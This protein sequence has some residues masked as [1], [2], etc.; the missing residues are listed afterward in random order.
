M[1]GTY[2]SCKNIYYVKSEN[3]RLTEGFLLNQKDETK[4]IVDEF[5]TLP[6]LIDES[7]EFE[8]VD[9]LH[10]MMKYKEHQLK[11]KKS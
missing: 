4:E 6:D 7:G 11:F 9:H 8:I 10:Y 5:S 1:F 3:P 2:W